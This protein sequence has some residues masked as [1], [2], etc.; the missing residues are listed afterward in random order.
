MFTVFHLYWCIIDVS[1]DN[2]IESPMLTVCSR[3]KYLDLKQTLSLIL[4]GKISEKM[5]L[6]H[7]VMCLMFCSAPITP[8]AEKCVPHVHYA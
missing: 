2:T 5:L 6:L 3:K 1:T 8:Q 7:W 4:R